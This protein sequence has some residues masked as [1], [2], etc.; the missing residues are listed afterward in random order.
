MIENVTLGADPELFIVNNAT[1]TVV[2]SI[3]LIPGKKKNAWVDPSWIKGYG[4]ETDNILAEFNIP[5]CHTKDE[6]LTHINFM[7]NFIR[8]FVQ[9]VNPDYDIKCIASMDC[10]ADQLDSD[11]ARLF[12]CDADYNV[13][14]EAKNPKPNGES[15]T[16]RSAGCHIH[17]GYDNKKTEISLGLIKYMDAYVGIPSLLI[18]NDTRRRSLY[19]KAGC[20]RLTPYGFEYR[21]LSSTMISSDENIAFMYDAT[22]RAINAYNNNLPIPT[23][24]EVQNCINNSNAEMANALIEKYNLLG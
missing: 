24:E 4:L 18:D 19:G 2:S 17:V 16:V 6:W 12:G 11:E 15:T 3:G 23:A 14:T 9:K 20:F 8:D 22:M 21:T 7:K 10:P 1:G 5:P 13:Y